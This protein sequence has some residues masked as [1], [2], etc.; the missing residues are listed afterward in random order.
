M[1]GGEVEDERLKVEGGKTIRQDLCGIIISADIDT[2]G[3]YD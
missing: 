3:R 2:Q 1:E